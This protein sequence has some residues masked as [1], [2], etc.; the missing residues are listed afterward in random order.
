M[1]KTSHNGFMIDIMKALLHVKIFVL[2]WRESDIVRVFEESHIPTIQ[3]KVGNVAGDIETF[4]RSEVQK[5]WKGYHGGKIHLTDD[6][7][8]ARVIQTLAE[9]AAGMSVLPTNYLEII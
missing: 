4:V 9:K 6:D 1:R 8:E 5:L 3:I 2:S 7:L